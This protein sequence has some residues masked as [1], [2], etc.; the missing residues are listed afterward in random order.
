MM[1]LN[2]WLLVYFLGVMRSSH[3][4]CFPPLDHE[5]VA[6]GNEEGL[7]VIHV[8]KDG[9]KGTS[10]GAPLQNS[11]EEWPFSSPLYPPPPF[12]LLR[13][14]PDGRQQKSAPHRPDAAGAAAGCY[15]RSQP[16]RAPLPHAGAGRPRDRVLQAGWDQRLP[17]HCVGPSAQRLAHL[18]VCGHEEADHL[19]WGSTHCS[20][21]AF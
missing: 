7:F 18:L 12:R 13:D 17:D 9:M 3:F 15:L 1:T 19:L 21:A 10:S 5:R 4:L 20:S 8:T 16:P 2:F 11:D 6:L 14:H